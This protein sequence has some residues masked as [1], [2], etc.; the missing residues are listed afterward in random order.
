MHSVWVTWF[1]IWGKQHLL[2]I[3]VLFFRKF[4]IVQHR[5]EWFNWTGQKKKTLKCNAPRHG[6]L[7]CQAAWWTPKIRMQRFAFECGFLLKNRRIFGSNFFISPRHFLLSKK[8]T[9]AQIAQEVNAGSDEKVSEYTVYHKFV[10][11]WG[12]VPMLTPVNCRKRQQWAREHQNWT[13]EQWKN[14]AWS[15]VSRFFYIA[16]MAGCVLLTWGIRM[17]YG[18][19]ASR[20]RQWRFGWCFAGK[21]WVLPCPCGCYFDMFH[22]P[23][24]ETVFP[25]GCGLFQQDN[26]SGMAWGA[27]LGLGLQIP[28]NSNQSNR[29]SVGCAEQ[30]SSIQPQLTGLKGSTAYILVPDTT[31]H[32]QGSRGVCASMG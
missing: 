9:V 25:G 14:V 8:P 1:Q 2:H 20:R 28:Q 11:A 22:L 31:A 13:T 19:K 7:V 16:W 21:P 32:L 15:D 24:M 5:I 30:T 6:I 27:Q 26:G 17:H 12:R 3:D 18:K 4:W 10:V 29:A 23:K